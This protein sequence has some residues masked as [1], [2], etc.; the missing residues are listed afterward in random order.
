MISKKEVKNIAALAR[1][2]VEEKDLEKF[3]NDLSAVLDWI[4]Q[5]KELD[6]SEV[7]PTAHITGMKD[8]V[9]KDRVDEFS[10]TEKIVDLFPEKKDRYNKV[11][12]VLSND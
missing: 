9:R 6:V 1:I 3:S 8:V 11:K 2:G 12:S 10:K 7:E 4:D 5:L